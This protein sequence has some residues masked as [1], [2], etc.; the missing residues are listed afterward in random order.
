MAAT[1]THIFLATTAG[2]AVV[3]A[4]AVTP[5]MTQAPRQADPCGG[6]SATPGRLP[7]G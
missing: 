3:A 6:R 4:L 5:V 7:G 1:T 2:A